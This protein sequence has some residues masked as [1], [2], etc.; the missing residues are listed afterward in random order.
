MARPRK[1]RRPGRPPLE[2]VHNYF[3][4][5]KDWDP[6]YYFHVD[7]DNFRRGPFSEHLSI[8]LQVSCFY[9]SAVAGREAS[10][11]LYGHRDSLTSFIPGDDRDRIAPCVGE[12]L[13]SK[14]QGNFVTFL[15]HDSMAF[16]QVALSQKKF[17]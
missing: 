15:P 11:Q 16:V 5:I 3:F 2:P 7:D 14:S 17:S 6:S 8:K 12:L 10:F 9:P 1:R 4:T 13:L